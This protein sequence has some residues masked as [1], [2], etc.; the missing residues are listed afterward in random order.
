VTDLSRPLVIR[1]REV[2]A[3]PIDV[4]ADRALV[5]GFDQEPTVLYLNVADRACTPRGSALPWSADD[6]DLM[7]ERPR[8]P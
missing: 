6:V 2:A 1:D 5:L 4:L 3:A 8:W 7:G